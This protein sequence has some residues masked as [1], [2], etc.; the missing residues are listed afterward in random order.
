M[1]ITKSELK[2]IV[3]EEVARVKKIKA[4]QEQKSKIEK[5]LNEM[6]ETSVLPEEGLEEMVGPEAIQALGDIPVA[7]LFSLPF[8]GIGAAYVFK[9]F[10][11]Q[12]KE[13]ASEIASKIKGG[14]TKG[15]MA[16]LKPI[17]ADIKAS[18]DGL[19]EIAGPETIQAMGD[20]PVAAY[21]LLP[22]ALTAI[23]TIFAYL[24]SA[25]GKEKASEIASKIK[26][27]DTKGA[28]SLAKAIAP[29]I[30]ASKEGLEEMDMA[31]GMAGAEAIASMPGM[32]V[33][34]Y[35]LAPAVGISAPLLYQ[36]FKGK[37]KEKAAEITAKVKGGDIAGATEIA[38]AI[39]PEVK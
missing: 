38:K 12:G 35:F 31:S 33:L 14:D 32:Q 30:K 29:E 3:Q 16:S 18:K 28:M 27:G 26:A 8:V 6:D 15:A 1:K 2:Q 23:G 9:Y 17:V 13:K 36:Y 7:V 10:Q 21:F 4:L 34:A 11:G 25:K 5:M 39:A 19:E 22:F 20:I 37:G 24:K